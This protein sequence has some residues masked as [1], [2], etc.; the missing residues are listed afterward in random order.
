MECRH[1]CERLPSFEQVQPY[2]LPEARRLEVCAINHALDPEVRDA[3]LKAW[4]DREFPDTAGF[5][6]FELSAAATSSLTIHAL[7]ALAAQSS[8]DKY[9]LAATRAAYFPWI[10][11]MS[12]MLDSYVDLAEDLA[13]GAHSYISHYTS[14]DA[15]T[16]RIQEIVASSLHLAHRLPRGRRHALIVTGMLAMYLTEQSTQSHAMHSASRTMM[17]TGGSLVRLVQPI[18]QTW[19]EHQRSRD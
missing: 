4:V 12:T 14:L 8:C 17:Q 10:R 7:L 13:S 2:V 6:S 18:L 5:H 9:E 15:A 16:V 3:G 1:R 19:R 11:L